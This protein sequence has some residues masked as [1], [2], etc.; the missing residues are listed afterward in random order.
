[1]T[2]RRKRKRKATTAELID[3]RLGHHIEAAAQLISEA[4]NR[5]TEELAHAN[6]LHREELDIRRE[7]LLSVLESKAMAD[8]AAQRLLGIMPD[9]SM[10]DLRSP[11]GRNLADLSAADEQRGPDWIKDVLAEDADAHKGKPS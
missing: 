4:F 5:M 8:K 10:Y 2:P 11:K 1:M 9:I 7:H 6:V 3:W